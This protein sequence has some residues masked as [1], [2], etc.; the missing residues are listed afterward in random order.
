MHYEQDSREARSVSCEVDRRYGPKV[1]QPERPPVPRDLWER[2]NKAIDDYNAYRGFWFA[3]GQACSYLDSPCEDI[4]TE[5]RTKM[6]AILREQYT[7]CAERWAAL[8]I[9]KDELLEQVGQFD[10]SPTVTG[11]WKQ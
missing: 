8:K 7:L 11:E 5:Q 2:R 6:L 10:T 4:C 1:P 9:E 3:L